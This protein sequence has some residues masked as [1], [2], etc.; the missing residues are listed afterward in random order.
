MQLSTSSHQ[1]VLLSSVRLTSRLRSSW[2]A[3]RI[4]S[5]SSFESTIPFRSSFDRWSSLCRPQSS[6]SIFNSQSTQIGRLAHSCCQAEAACCKLLTLPEIA[7]NWSA[8]FSLP[9]Y[10]SQRSTRSRFH[11]STG[12]YSDSNLCV[13][14]SWQQKVCLGKAELQ[15]QSPICAHRQETGDRVYEANRVLMRRK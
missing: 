2:M 11:S 4:R 9:R 6:V 14:W 3:S 13:R 8:Y 12:F 5:A 7:L 10:V 1:P 15:P